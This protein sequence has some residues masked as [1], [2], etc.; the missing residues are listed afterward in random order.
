MPCHVFSG[1]PGF[2]GQIALITGVIAG[3]FVRKQGGESGTGLNASQNLDGLTNKN[4]QV[5]TPLTQG[6][7]QIL[8]AFTHEMVVLPGSICL[9]PERGL[10]NVQ[11]QNGT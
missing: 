11:A 10:D 6:D 9:G 3:F 4:T 7:G 8:Q 5:A 2:H 1:A